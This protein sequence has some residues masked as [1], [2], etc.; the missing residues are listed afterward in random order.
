MNEYIAYIIKAIP[1]NN[2]NERERMKASKSRRAFQLRVLADRRYKFI[3]F[4]HIRFISILISFM[5]DA[6]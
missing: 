2:E 1:T 6:N 3:A 4:E 5:E